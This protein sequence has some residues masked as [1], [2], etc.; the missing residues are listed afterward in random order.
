M[1][2]KLTFR[3]DVGGQPFGVI[4]VSAGMATA[5]VGRAV[6]ANI[7]LTQALLWMREQNPLPQQEVHF[8]LVNTFGR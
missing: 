1:T 8:R 5:R 2:T 7:L 3:A 4:M 6:R